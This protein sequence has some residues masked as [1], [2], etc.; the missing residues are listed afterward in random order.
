LT[1][2]LV[3]IAYPMSVRRDVGAG[4]VRPGR[5]RSEASSSLTTPIGLAFR[6]QRLN[7]I[8]WCLAMSDRLAPEG[9]STEL[10]YCG[11]R[12]YCGLPWGN[13]AAA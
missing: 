7:L 3:V 5:G 10:D 6:L 9:R 12:F 1:A 2:L 13:I 11:L 4:L 8:V